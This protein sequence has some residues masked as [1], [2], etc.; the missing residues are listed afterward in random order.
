MQSSVS[1][2]QIIEVITMAPFQGWIWKTRGDDRSEPI[3]ADFC[4]FVFSLFL[5]EGGRTKRRKLSLFWLFRRNRKDGQTKIYV[6]WSFRLHCKT[7]KIIVISSS[8]RN[9]DNIC[10]FV[11]KAKGRNNNNIRLFD[12]SPFHITYTNGQKKGYRIVYHISLW[13]TGT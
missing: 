6:I 5:V 4:H 1:Y 7:T 13:K 9:K 12:L 2:K 11:A 3:V 8:S 10:L